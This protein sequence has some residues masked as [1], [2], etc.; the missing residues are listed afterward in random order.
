MVRTLPSEIYDREYYLHVC[1]GYEEFLASSVAPRLMKALE[2]GNI[3]PGMRVLDVGCGR[4]ELAVKCAEAGCK[5]WAIDQSAAALDLSKR[6]MKNVSTDGETRRIALQRMS[7]LSLA[8]PDQ[9]F[10]RIFLI[11]V[12]EHLYPEELAAAL[13]EIGRV[14]KAGGRL[15][16]HTAPNAWLIRPIYRIAGLLF[17]WSKHPFH[18]NEQSILSLRKTLGTLGG[19][20][21][22]AMEKVPG[23]FTLGVGPAADH[24]PHL[25]RIA[26]LLDRGFDNRLAAL[27][28]VL[29]GLNA[30]LGTDI[31][32][33]VEFP[34]EESVNKVRGFRA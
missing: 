20:V 4:G 29:P 6:F 30:I 1:G 10:D 11:D 15:V 12:V 27:L 14:T 31:W 19:R 13:A 16:I 28:S 33:T 18:V 7:A 24:S 17:R 23:F 9:S 25:G 34:G 21:V 5:V 2:L 22:I 26:R 32:A 3:Q 8:F